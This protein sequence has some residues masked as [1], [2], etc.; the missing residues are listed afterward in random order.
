M[1]QHVIAKAVAVVLA[2]GAVTTA[3]LAGPLGSAPQVET[4]SALTPVA[5]AWDGGVT[6]FP[7]TPNFAFFLRGGIWAD[8]NNGVWV[9]LYCCVT[10]RSSI[11]LAADGVF[12]EPSGVYGAPIVYDGGYNTLLV[13]F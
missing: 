3:A 13:P 5:F 12:Y 4:R 11:G 7:N 2:M 9:P 1:F 10:G 8:S 6:L